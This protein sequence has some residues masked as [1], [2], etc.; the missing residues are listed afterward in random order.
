[1]F[2][3]TFHEFNGKVSDVVGI[4]LAF[5]GQWSAQVFFADH[6]IS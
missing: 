3:L 6:V 2:S 5:S 1:M 4:C